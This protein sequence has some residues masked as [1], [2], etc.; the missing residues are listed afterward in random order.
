MLLK[1]DR[2]LEARQVIE[3]LRLQELDNFTQDSRGKLAPF[4]FLKPELEILKTFNAQDGGIIR[5]DQELRDLRTTTQ[6]V[7]TPE[8]SKRIIEL[9]QLLKANREQTRQFITNPTTQALIQQLKIDGKVP[10]IKDEEVQK[11]QGNLRDLRA[12]QQEAAL[13][14]PMIFDDR[15]EILVITP[16]TTF[17]RI[18]PNSGRTILNPQIAEFADLLSNPNTDPKPIAQKL[19]QALIAPLEADLKQAKIN[20]LIY[21][22]DQ[23]LRSIPINALHDGEQWLTQRFQIS[24]LTST[25]T[26]D[27]T[28]P[29]TATPKVLAGTISEDPQ[30]KY[31]IN[32][33]NNPLSFRGLPG[34]KLE[35]NSIRSIFPT[36]KTLIEQEFSST[37]IRE[38]SEQFNILHF[39]THGFFDINQPQQSFILLGSQNAQ[40]SQYATLTDFKDWQLSGIDLVTLSACETAIAAE[41]LDYKLGIMGLGYQ[42]EIAGARATIASLWKVNDSSTAV[43]MKSFYTHLSQNKSKSEALRLAQVDLLNIK[44]LGSKN[45]AIADISRFVGMNEGNSSLSSDRPK[46]SLYQGYSHPYYWAP[47]ILIGNGR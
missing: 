45:Q 14:S 29:R 7:R 5:A 36:A 10:E 18:V 37:L 44:D 47:F 23:R 31:D 27:F 2:L 4:T 35:V 21:S 46:S 3:L 34:G 42:F 11:I 17:R 9:E 32:L 1:N 20:T 8:Q 25:S 43:L 28:M 26:L 41:K 30:K 16:T 24:Y 38:N 6:T 12:S 15:L 39:A 22:P 19:Y 13:I 40:G 33:N